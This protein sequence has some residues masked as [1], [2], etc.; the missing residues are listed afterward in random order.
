MLGQPFLRLFPLLFAALACGRSTSSD[1]LHFSV[2]KQD[3]GSLVAGELKTVTFPFSVVGQAV[4]LDASD[5]SCG[6]LETRIVVHGSRVSWGET[7]PVGTQGVIEVD[8]DTAGFRG[9]KHSTVVLQGNGPGLPQTLAFDGDLQPWFQS[10][11]QVLRMGVMTEET[12]AEF[13]VRVSAP[14]PFRLLKLRASAPPLEVRGLP[15]L[16]SSTEQNFRV[17]LPVDASEEGLHHVFLSFETDQKYRFLLPVEWETSGLTW[18]RP[19]KLLLG[20]IQPGIS[21]QTSVEVGVREGRMKKPEI[22]V[23][24]ISGATADC[25]TLEEQ[26][27]Y[28]IRLQLLENQEPGP[29]SGKLQ[30]RFL[31]TR[32][33]KTVEV[34]KDVSIYGL[35]R[36][37]SE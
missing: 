17:V 23:E 4:R 28:L 20:V 32:R 16:V 8:W 22:K 9:M 11:P 31:W 6:C 26:S 35:V 5:G 7:L 34:E 24:G 15:S 21:A 37:H 1:G 12:E 14:E 33:G 19:R 18:I 27:R 10:T 36:S 25:V 29:F 13:L 2:L 3:L 30:V